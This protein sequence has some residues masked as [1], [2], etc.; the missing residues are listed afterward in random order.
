MIRLI[1]DDWETFSDD[2]DDEWVNA[3]KIILKMCFWG[4]NF[5]NVFFD[6]AILKMS[7]LGE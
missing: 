7:F 5:E 3:I 4:S 1:I 6:G 2:F